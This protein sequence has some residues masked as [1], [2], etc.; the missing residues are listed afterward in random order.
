[1]VE[2]GDCRRLLTDVTA[3]IDHVAPDRD[4]G[5]AGGDRVDADQRRQ[6]ASDGAVVEMLV[7]P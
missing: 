4:R 3:G 7:Q 1:M 5:Q 2:D 6:Q